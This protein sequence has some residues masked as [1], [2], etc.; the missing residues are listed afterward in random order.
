MGGELVRLLFSLILQSKFAKQI[1]VNMRP[2]DYKLVVSSA[3]ICHPCSR[4]L[5]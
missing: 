1:K 2:N 3:I 5:S 4:V